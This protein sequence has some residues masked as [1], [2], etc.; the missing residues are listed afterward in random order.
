M[1]GVVVGVAV[2]FAAGRWSATALRVAEP[3]RVVTRAPA[4][5]DTW[6][7]V[8]V[9]D[10]DTLVARGAGGEEH[11]RLRAINTPERGQAGFEEATAAL[12]EMAASGA[13]ARLE[14]ETPGKL[15]RDRYGR[16]LAYVF[17]G[18]LNT[19]VEMV[20]QGWAAYETKYGPS[21]FDAAMREAANEAQRARRGLWAK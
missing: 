8:R 2:G 5:A 3:P 10:G 16:V 11:V 18:G 17:V 9:I 6:T 14:Y 12:R 1:A 4:S 19:S 7:V 15:D 20:R 21:R 13:A